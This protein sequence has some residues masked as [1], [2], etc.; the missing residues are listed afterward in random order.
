MFTQKFDAAAQAAVLKMLD[1]DSWQS[2]PWLVDLVSHRATIS[3]IQSETIEVD[4]KLP[5]TSEHAHCTGTPLSSRFPNIIAPGSEVEEAVK[6][7]VLESAGLNQDT[8]P[9]EF[10]FVSNDFSHSEGFDYRII[11]ADR[12]KDHQNS[13][14]VHFS[15]KPTQEEFDE[16]YRYYRDRTHHVHVNHWM[17]GEWETITDEY[18]PNFRKKLSDSSISV[19]VDW[20]EGSTHRIKFWDDRIDAQNYVYFD[21]RPS[22]MLLAKYHVAKAFAVVESRPE[23]V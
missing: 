8:A 16:Q 7:S 2:M 17:N 12:L 5:A 4:Y 13:W 14:A 3:L 1:G 15:G 10:F 9:S 21:Y 18:T 11:V 19:V 20:P 6:A 22:G 23:G